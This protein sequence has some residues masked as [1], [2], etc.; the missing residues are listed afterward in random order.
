MKITVFENNNP[1][2]KLVDEQTTLSCFKREYLMPAIRMDEF[3]RRCWDLVKVMA[4]WGRC[5]S[6]E[7]SACQGSS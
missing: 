6:G 7:V 3:G 4:C 1:I 5:D 2:P